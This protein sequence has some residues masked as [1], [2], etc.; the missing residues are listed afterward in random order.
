MAAS[1]YFKA[2][3][4]RETPSMRGG[5]KILTL[6]PPQV[7]KTQRDHAEATPRVIFQSATLHGIANSLAA[8][9]RSPALLP[10]IRWQPPRPLRPLQP[11]TPARPAT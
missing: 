2:K 5:M 8:V 3:G 11:K 10:A 7:D 4:Y 1:V 6:T 9:E